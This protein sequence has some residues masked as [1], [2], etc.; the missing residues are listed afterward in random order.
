MKEIYAGNEE[1]IKGMQ[2]LVV[3]N[4]S[5]LSD[6]TRS[7]VYSRFQAVKYFCIE[8]NE[9]QK[10]EIS[11][12]SI[13]F[14]APLENR[15]YIINGRKGSLER[16]VLLHE[17]IHSI[18][19]ENAEAVKQT[20]LINEG[21]SK[22]EVVKPNKLSLF[23]FMRCNNGLNEGATEFFTMKF[24]GNTQTIHYPFF[25]HLISILSEEC[26]DK[27][28]KEM[29][30]SGNVNGL[31]KLIKNTFKLKSDY[32]V[33]KLF[34][35]SDIVDNF[36]VSGNDRVDYLTH[37]REMYKTLIKMKL[38]KIVCE[39]KRTKSPIDVVKEFD[40]KSFLHKG[41][42]KNFVDLLDKGIVS[43]IATNKKDLL[44]DMTDETGFKN[45]QEF[46]TYMADKICKQ[47]YRDIYEFQNAP[48]KL[49][50]KSVQTLNSQIFF[51]HSNFGLLQTGSVLDTLLNHLHGPNQKI[52]LSGFS[53]T[54][55]HE[56]IANILNSPYNLENSYKHFAPS[57]L[58]EYING[59]GSEFN[60]FCNPSAVKYIMP[61]IQKINMNVF[62]NN[63]FSSA[64]Q[65]AKKSLFNQNEKSETLQ[66]EKI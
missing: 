20:G 19:L 26:G 12:S 46:V 1:L 14:F 4:T 13:A 53:K 40:V 7:K 51:R 37:V 2:Q 45:M 35:Q 29:F 54:E 27:E 8:E 66:R 36:T 39:Y 34:M 58:V 22:I 50:I 57:D 6:K 23:S 3:M 17:M 59:G 16:D 47:D 31:K 33:D 41:Y 61:C 55:R 52:N 43:S 10:Y 28:F 62:L 38:N 5:D 24:L 15:V 60:A 64:Y 11:K 63:K 48:N 21:F 44:D 30:F 18:T 56:F 25:V 32:L 49:M 65:E 42:C 9:V